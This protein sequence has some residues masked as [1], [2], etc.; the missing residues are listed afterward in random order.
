MLYELLHG[1]LAAA[2][3]FN[4]LALTALVLAVPLYSLWAYGRM[5]GRRIV[6]WPDYRW[7]T[8]VAVAAISA[9]FVM[10]N[11]PFGPFTALRV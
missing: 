2:A 10:R 4:A 3:K 9:W 1:D 8:P 7:T 5:R 11:L 6:S